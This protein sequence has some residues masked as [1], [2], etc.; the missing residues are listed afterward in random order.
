MLRV[1]FRP[2]AQCDHHEARGHKHRPEEQHHRGH[3]RSNHRRARQRQPHDAQCRVRR[4]WPVRHPRIPVRNRTPH[5]VPHLPAQRRHPQ[6]LAQ[7]CLRHSQRAIQIQRRQIQDQSQ[8]ERMSAPV[9]PSHST[10]QVLPEL[11]YGRNA[12]IWFDLYNTTKSFF[13]CRTVA[14]GALTIVSNRPFASNWEPSAQRMRLLSWRRF[15][16]ISNSQ[17]FN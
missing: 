12:Q 5:E 10:R 2:R 11:L 1:R 13:R 14:N 7:V 16:R 17:I 9:V 3:R 4:K 6:Q 8:R 15:P